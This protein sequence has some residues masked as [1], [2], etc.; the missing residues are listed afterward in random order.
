MYGNG[1]VR[2]WSKAQATI[3]TSSAESELLA[4]VKGAAESVGIVSLG[5][6]LGLTLKVRLHMDAAAALGIL[7]R[8]GVGKVRHLDVG[9]LWL[10]EKQLRKII[11]MHKVAGLL[12]PSDLLTKHLSRERV[13]CYSSMLNYRFADGR[14]AAAA[15]LHSIDESRFLRI[16]RSHSLFQALVFP[17]VSLM[18]PATVGFL[19]H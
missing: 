2:T 4:S 9:T 10:Q 18:Y 3:A 16:V 6:D 13:D 5:A 15:K 7:E 8:R 17:I 19:S 1:C 14:A 12:N 11:E